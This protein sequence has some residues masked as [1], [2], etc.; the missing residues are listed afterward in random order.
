MPEQGSLRGDCAA[1]CGHQEAVG[2]WVRITVWIEASDSGGNTT[3][4]S[5]MNF[6]CSKCSANAVKNVA[7]LVIE[8]DI[9]PT[10]ARKA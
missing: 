4:V 1:A 10:L 2:S 5:R 7:A 6:L 9:L 3:R 8:K